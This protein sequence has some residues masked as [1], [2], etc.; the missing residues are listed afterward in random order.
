MSRMDRSETSPIQLLS[1]RLLPQVS[2]GIQLTVNKTCVAGAKRALPRRDV[3]GAD[4]LLVALACSGKVP[5]R[6]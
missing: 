4:R 6:A 1:P 3:I 2:G 5:V